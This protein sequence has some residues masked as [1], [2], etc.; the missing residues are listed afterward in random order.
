VTEAAPAAG[1]AGFWRR[2]AAL[3]VDSLALGAVGTC[4]GLLWYDR[5]AALGSRGRLLGG[6][7]ALGYFGFLNSR[8]AGGQTLGKRALKIRV[9]DALGREISLPRSTLR[10]LVLLLPIA[11]NGVYVPGSEAS[12]LV[13]AALGVCIFGL[14]GALVY[15]YVFNRRTRQCPHDLAARTF[16]VDASGS[17]EVRGRIWK[18]HL[19]VVGVWLV[20][21]AVGLGPLGALL[22]RSPIF[23][24][25]LE[26]QQAAQSAVPDADV[27]VRRGT[28]TVATLQGRS[29]AS[30]VDV[31]VASRVRPE[32]FEDLADSIA[33]AVLS[34]H[35]VARDAD[36]VRISISYGYD[37]MISSMSTSQTFAHSPRDWAQRF[38]ERAR[39]AGTGAGHP[40][41]S[42]AG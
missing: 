6:A 15:L 22:G 26:L 3:A 14:G 24:G 9:V 21:L 23:E 4:L 34:A 17:G 16:V 13:A 29:S 30:Y 31:Q 5:L 25:L 18:P 38:T 41:R 39:T 11:L 10:A 35:P 1:I 40:V 2:L 12:L 19:A 37:I 42:E 8:L 27:A 32:S 28:A 33:E 36:E 20:A 7:I